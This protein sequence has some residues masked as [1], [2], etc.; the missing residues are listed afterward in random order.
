MTLERILTAVLFLASLIAGGVFLKQKNLNYKLAEHENRNKPYVKMED[1]FKEPLTLWWGGVTGQYPKYIGKK[2]MKGFG[3]EEY[4]AYQIK[5]YL[6]KQYGVKII[7]WMASPSRLEREFHVNRRPVCIY[8]YKWKD[9]DNHFRENKDF[10]I[11]YAFDFGGEVSHSILIRKNEMRRFVDYYN[12]KGDLSLKKLLDAKIFSTAIIKGEKYPAAF[13]E[14]FKP[15]INGDLALKSEYEGTIYIMVASDNSQLLKMLK[16]G[17]VDFI[18]DKLISTNHYRKANISFQEFGRIIY[19]QNRVEGFRDPKMERYSVR[20]NLHPVN[21]HIMAN[22]NN[23]ILKNRRYWNLKKE[24][25]IYR[26]KFDRFYTA[27][28]PIQ[29]RFNSQ[30]DDAG[31]WYEKYHRGENLKEPLPIIV[32]KRTI[33]PPPQKPII[34]KRKIYYKVIRHGSHLAIFDPGLLSDVLNPSKS[35]ITHPM[36][37]D[38]GQLVTE[39]LEDEVLQIAKSIEAKEISEDELIKINYSKVKNFTVVGPTLSIQTFKKIVK[40]LNSLNGLHVLLAKNGLERAIVANIKPSITK[41]S[42]VGLNL[43]DQNINLF[44]R[45]QKNNLSYLDLSASILMPSDIGRILQQQRKTLSKLILTQIADRDNLYKPF[46]PDKWLQLKYLNLGIGVYL[47]LGLGGAVNDHLDKVISS[48]GPKMESLI[49]KSYINPDQLLELNRCCKNLKTFEAFIPKLTRKVELPRHIENLKI[50]IAPYQEASS[51]LQ[52]IEF[53]K[54]LQSFE[55]KGNFATNDLSYLS[56]FLTRKLHTLSI[57]GTAE[58]TEVNEFIDSAQ[59]F[60]LKSLTLDNLGIQDHHLKTIAKRFTLL[61]SLNLNNNFISDLSAS[62]ITNFKF[63]EELVLSRNFLSHKGINEIFK[64]K[65]IHNNLKTLF[66]DGVENFDLLKINDKFP[67][68]FENLSTDNGYSNQEAIALLKKLPKSIRKL[69]VGIFLCQDSLSE[70]LALIPPKIELLSVSVCDGLANYADFFNSLPPT[71]YKASIFLHI[72][73]LPTEQPFLPPGLLTLILNWKLDKKQLD[74]ESKRLQNENLLLNSLP[75][76]LRFADFK[77][78]RSSD[79][80][81]KMLIKPYRFH[82]FLDGPKPNINQLIRADVLSV[83][84]AT[85]QQFIAGMNQNNVAIISQNFKGGEDLGELK[86]LYF[87]DPRLLILKLYGPNTTDE[88]IKTLVQFNLTQLRT[89]NLSNSSLTGKGLTLLLNHLSKNMIDLSIAGSKLS[90]KD[91][92][93]IIDILPP[94]LYK[95]DVSGSGFGQ[96]GYQKFRDWADAQEKKHGFRPE[97]IE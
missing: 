78:F 83:S 63:L 69:G 16:A 79:N 7:D 40:S 75:S 10:L 5:T 21:R 27:S 53:P 96:K 90:L 48:L 3:W 35:F 20:C 67:M 17:R 72:S 45:L 60:D 13:S 33:L 93:K 70:A 58:E 34:A 51:G 86:P 15:A 43:I 31:W 44:D 29:L 46:E 62:S 80:A 25:N 55:I 82:S 64:D 95:L 91:V 1:V 61:K 22:I 41:L 14:V 39:H 92:E 68:N 85:I 49:L 54:N 30:I 36:E 38:Y 84:K 89:L 88:F 52:L 97:L 42:L 4:P 6:Q 11:S 65:N 26:R 94:R 73:R 9:P 18:L 71:L 12:E 77:P 24:W 56:K 66:M 57:T 23:Y 2:G 81:R 19:E 37:V 47:N 28:S 32:K 59:F 8:P 76:G 74:D 50:T 87:K